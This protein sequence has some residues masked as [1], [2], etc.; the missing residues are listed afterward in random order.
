MCSKVRV[1]LSR[2][3]QDWTEVRECLVRAFHHY[4]L[5]KYLIPNEQR[6]P[7]FLRRYLEAIYDVTIRN[8]NSILLV[9]RL[10]DNNTVIGGA[11]VVPPSQDHGGWECEKADDFYEA[12]EKYK[13]K[14]IDLEA[15]ERMETYEEWD[16]ENISKHV[17]STKVP[18]WNGIFCAVDPKYAGRG[19]GSMSYNECLKIINNFRKIK[20]TEA[21]KM[22]N[23]SKINIRKTAQKL[24]GYYK[25][26]INFKTLTAFFHSLSILSHRS[27]PIQSVSVNN[28]TVESENTEIQLKKSSKRLTDFKKSPMLF[29][30][31][32]SR[33]AVR[34]HQKIGFQS[35]ADIPYYDENTS[36]DEEKSLFNVNVLMMD[37][38]DA[39]RITDFT[40][41]LNCAMPGKQKM[42]FGSSTQTTFSPEAEQ[43]Q[44]K[45]NFDKP[46]LINKYDCPNIIRNRG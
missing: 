15:F 37:P 13:L 43:P 23:Q 24:L 34:F 21:K 10:S 3:E 28:T 45:H 39:D 18:L 32:H 19:C 41:K 6:R 40:Q 1:E 33:Q 30:I 36:I 14:E 7:E 11:M 4:S 16:Y 5:Y 17:C 9:G 35:V 31:S 29:M 8:G 25:N 38:L 42:R 27:P 22:E 2:G 20:M 44:L 12:Y 46:C 26:Q